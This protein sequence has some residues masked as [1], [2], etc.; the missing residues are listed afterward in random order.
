MGSSQSLLT[1]Q[2]IQ[3][4]LDTTFLSRKEVLRVVNR[5]IQLA[6]DLKKSNKTLKLYLWR[7][8]LGINHSRGRCVKPSIDWYG[9]GAMISL[10][11][12]Q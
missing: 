3:N 2:E 6:P 12:S 5:F 1:E 9:V 4:Y 10:K 11:Y 8:E 7:I